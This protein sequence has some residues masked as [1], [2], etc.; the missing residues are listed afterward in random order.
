MGKTCSMAKL[1]LDWDP[2]N[3]FVRACVICAYFDIAACQIVIC[4]FFRVWYHAI[5]DV[6]TQ[7]MTHSL[8]PWSNIMT[9]KVKAAISL[10]ILQQ[11]PRLYKRAVRMTSP[12]K[13]SGCG[14][15]YLY[16]S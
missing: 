13:I 12:P 11:S 2:G 4:I 10:I 7:K 5:I 9:I 3:V 8:S 16:F 6:T 14:P 1:A 15:A